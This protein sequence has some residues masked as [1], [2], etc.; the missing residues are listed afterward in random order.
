[1]WACHIKKG[2]KIMKKRQAKKQ[3]IRKKAKAQG[4]RKQNEVARDKGGRDQK[5]LSLVFCA[6]NFPLYCKP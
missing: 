1:M 3:G 4:T 2:C 6:L 5:I